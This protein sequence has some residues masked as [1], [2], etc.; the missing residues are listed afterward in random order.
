M[1]ISAEALAFFLSLLPPGVISSEPARI[2]VA[3]EAGETI[4]VRE[5]DV[6]CSER[7][8]TALRSE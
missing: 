1:C 4:W 7:P 6:W 5:G 3:A 8:V 2:T